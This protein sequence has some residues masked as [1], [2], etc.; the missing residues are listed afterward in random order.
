MMA[1]S[2]SGSIGTRVGLP[3]GPSPTTTFHVL[4]VTTQAPGQVLANV[5]N[6]GI[7]ATVLPATHPL[8]QSQ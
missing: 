1:N 2:G 7:Q 8:S 6:G 4:S 5:I 3:T